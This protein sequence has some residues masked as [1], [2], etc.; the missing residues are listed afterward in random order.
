MV[1][2]LGRFL[3]QNTIALIALFLVLG[4]SAYAASTA[5][6]GKSIKPNSIPKNRL[7]K[8]AIKQLKGNRGPQ[9]PP[10]SQGIQGVQGV[11]GPPGPITGNLPG[12]V[13]LRG[14]YMVS[15][16]NG[17][18]TIHN[19][20]SY[21]LRLSAAPTV[22]YIMVG[23][24]PPPACPGSVT[25]PQAAPGNLCVYEVQATNADTFRGVCDAEVSGCPFGSAGREGFGV[26][27]LPQTGG[28]P[29]YVFGSWAVTGPTSAAPQHTP[30]GKPTLTAP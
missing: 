18:S 11:P 6:N 1:R 4:G 23:T 7:T 30:A 26:F 13:T 29:L 3:R 20:V 27:T 12:G 19:A 2:G 25:D 21:G 8:T 22:N 15:G 24:T 28:S 5:I 16:D 14:N 10:G 17:G 9:G